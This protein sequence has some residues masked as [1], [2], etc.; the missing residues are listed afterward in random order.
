MTWDILEIS[1]NPSE[2]LATVLDWS[3]TVFPSALSFI[4][5]V[6]SWSKGAVSR[7]LKTWGGGLDIY[8]TLIGM[9]TIFWS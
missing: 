7:N 1:S 4:S 9:M 5:S 6:G 8:E 2:M 3:M